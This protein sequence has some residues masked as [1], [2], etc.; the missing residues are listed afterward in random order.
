MM[1]RALALDLVKAL[2][3]MPFAN[4]ATGEDHQGISYEQ[5]FLAHRERLERVVNTI[6]A[7]L[8]DEG[9]SP[10]ADLILRA[11]VIAYE[12]APEIAGKALQ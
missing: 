1:P 5:R 7:H 10:S 11:V 8:A 4:D 9:L 12:T 6:T 2:S 3:I